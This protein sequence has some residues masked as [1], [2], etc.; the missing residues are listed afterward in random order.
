MS[1]DKDL[2]NRDEHIAIPVT[3][4]GTGVGADKEDTEL[5]IVF[6]EFSATC[7]DMMLLV[8]H[9]VFVR[10]NMSGICLQECKSMTRLI[11]LMDVAL[12]F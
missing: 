7:E 4:N 2:D 1:E 12:Q 10:E 3:W 8:T 6:S 11:N 9:D 5:K